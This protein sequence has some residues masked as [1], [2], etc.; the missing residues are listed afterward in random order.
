M[1][2]YPGIA[3]DRDNQCI[4]ALMDKQALETA[5]R[6]LW[7]SW[8]AEGVN[9]EAAKRLFNNLDDLERF[10]FSSEAKRQAIEKSANIYIK[11]FSKIFDDAHKK[12]MEES[13]AQDKGDDE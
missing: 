12:F 11:A 4:D 8:K 9:A 3:Q 7:E 6:T 10:E 1:K 13:W 5:K 2:Y